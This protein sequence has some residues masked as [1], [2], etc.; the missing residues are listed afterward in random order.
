MS[1]AGRF[2]TMLCVLATGC[3]S[4]PPARLYTLSASSPTAETALD[5]SVSVGPVSIPAAVDRPQIVVATAA[6]QV[7]LD[8]FNRWASPLQENLSIVIAENLAALLGSSRV[9]RFPKTSSAD[10]D[11]RVAIEVTRFESVPGQWAT[12]DATWTVRRTADGVVQTHRT[13]VRE[14]VVPDNSFEALAAAHSRAAARLSQDIGGAIR[15]MIE[16]AATTRQDTI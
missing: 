5:I 7:R 8:D 14:A 10:A 12:L 4:T 9:T 1:L 6:N 15:G 13:S 3:A 2:G 16:R 11:F